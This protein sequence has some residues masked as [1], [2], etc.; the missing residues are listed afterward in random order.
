MLHEFQQFHQGVH[1]DK[2][3]IKVNRCSM[4]CVLIQDPH[5]SAIFNF[6]SKNQVVVYQLLYNK[7]NATTVAQY[8]HTT[9]ASI[10]NDW[11]IGEVFA[12]LRV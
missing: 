4:V 2:W 10:L 11:E 7:C 5:R 9:L 1:W 3:N 6:S 8:D 12:K